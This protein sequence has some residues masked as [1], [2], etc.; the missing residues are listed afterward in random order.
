MENNIKIEDGAPRKNKVHSVLAHSYSLYFLLFLIGVCLDLIFG[1]QI[2]ADSIMLP[3]GVI[4]LAF[5]SILSFWAQLSSRKLDKNNLSK[6]AFTRGPYSYSRHPTHWGLFFLVL[7]FGIMVNATFIILST[8]I[9]FTV[10]KL[11]F[12]KKQEDILAE[13]Y[14]D[15]YLQYKK[16]V[17]L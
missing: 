6:E 11:F 3:V 12:I 13:K 7:G 10:S 17:K 8:L 2:F 15:P 16:S 4:L 1:Y 14:G 9:S 5:G